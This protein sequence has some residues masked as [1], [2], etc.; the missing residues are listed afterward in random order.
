MPSFDFS[1]EAKRDIQWVFNPLPVN[2]PEGADNSEGMLRSETSVEGG[3]S[4]ERK[5]EEVQ[6]G[7]SHQEAHRC[8]QRIALTAM[9]FFFWGS[10]PESQGI[11]IVSALAGFAMDKFSSD[12]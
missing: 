1:S 4:V 3:L 7:Y 9:A 11:M 5:Q 6:L 8:A 10:S 12:K 2:K